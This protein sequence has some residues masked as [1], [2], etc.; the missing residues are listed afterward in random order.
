MTEREPLRPLSDSQREMMEEAVARYQGGVSDTVRVHLLGRGLTEE[1]VR[2]AR[3]GVVSDPLPGHEKYRNM[4]SIPYLDRQGRALSLRFRCLENHNHR[5]FHHG[6]YMSMV[7]E[8]AR[9][10]NVRAIHEAD[11]EISVTEGE[12]DCIVLNQ[13]GLPA[14]AIPGANAWQSHHRIMLA[15][16]S[17]VWVWGDPDEAGAEFNRTLTKALH[18]ARSVQLRGGDVNDTYQFEGPEA[19]YALVGKEWND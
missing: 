17:R 15:G 14:V 13:I 8:P 11:E 2:T 9:M 18:T 10:Y 16:F 12:L 5:D 3:L 19:I 6:K 1:S 7:D 4:L